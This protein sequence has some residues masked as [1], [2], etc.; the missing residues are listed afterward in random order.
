MVQVLEGPLTRAGAGLSEDSLS[1]LE[2]AACVRGLHYAVYYT[3]EK[4][5]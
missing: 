3:N 1:S 2:L 4:L 5:V